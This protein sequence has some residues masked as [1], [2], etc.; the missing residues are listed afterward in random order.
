MK[1]PTSK[2]L[3]DKLLNDEVDEEVKEFYVNMNKWEIKTNTDNKYVDLTPREKQDWDIFKR[4]MND[5]RL[6]TTNGHNKFAND[7]E[8][9]SRLG[10]YYFYLL[11]RQNAPRKKIEPFNVDQEMR[12][13]LDN[14]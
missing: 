1:D 10:K 3:I 12:D 11:D 9:A 5:S 7:P 4:L 13:Y 8:L 14:Y 6:K 2:W